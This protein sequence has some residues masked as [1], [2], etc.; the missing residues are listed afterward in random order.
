MNRPFAAT[1]ALVAATSSPLLA[2]TLP[3][4][5]G[6]PVRIESQEAS[7]EFRFVRAQ[8]FTMSV[9]AD[10]ASDTIRVSMASLTRLEVRQPRSGLSGAG[11]GFLIGAGGGAVA[12]FALAA[13]AYEQCESG[14]LCVFN[15]SRG[16][17][18]FLGAIVFG[19]LGGVGGFLVG[20]AWPGEHW[21]EVPLPN[22]LGITPGRDG[23]L[24]LG[25]GYSF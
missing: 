12:G 5:P 8:R 1:L 21:Q 16:E 19:G 6:D 13:L 20:L 25:L 9:Q 15:F 2:Q 17:E 7:G 18:A 14:D 11:R 22:Q 4:E 3:L 10:S 24:A 23:G